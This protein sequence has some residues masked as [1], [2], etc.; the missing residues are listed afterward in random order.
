MKTK[1]RNKNGEEEQEYEFPILMESEEIVVLF[2]EGGVGTV[3]HVEDPESSLYAVG[4]HLTD[5]VMDVFE[6]LS[7][8]FEIVL[9]NVELQD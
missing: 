5:W 7:D 2:S 1:L 4:E 9:D 3:V 8:D 6:P